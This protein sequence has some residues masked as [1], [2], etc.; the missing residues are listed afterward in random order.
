MMSATENTSLVSW[1][2]YLNLLF[3]INYY[4]MPKFFLA[5]S[6]LNLNGYLTSLTCF[7]NCN[8]IMHSFPPILLTLCACLYV[9]Q[10][11]LHGRSFEV[12]ILWKGVWLCFGSFFHIFCCVVMLSIASAVNI[13]LHRFCTFVLNN[14]VSYVQKI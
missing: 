1:V 4:I 11:T 3:L 9:V 7:V 8:Q 10:K 5:K 6:A 2:F 14:I 13:S 12:Y